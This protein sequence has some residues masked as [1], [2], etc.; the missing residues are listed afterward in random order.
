MNDGSNETT[1]QAAPRQDSRPGPAE[2]ADQR[3]VNTP[4][5]EGSGG[6]AAAAAVPGIVRV[7]ANFL[8]LPLFALDNKHLRT[9]DGI[10]CSGTFRRQGQTY[11]FTFTATRNAGTFYPGP[12]A[13]SVHFAL[14]SF[15]TER[16]LP[17]QNPIVFTW[18][19]LCGRLDIH[20]SGKTIR[21]LRRALLATKGLM[22]D[23]HHALYLKPDGKAL[24]SS[25][26]LRRVVSLYDELEFF[27]TRRQDGTTADVNAVWLSRWYLDNLNALYSGPLQFGLWRQL[28]EHSFIASRLYE[29]LFFKFYRGRDELRFNYATLVK[30]IPARMER[31]ASDAKRQLQP[32]FDLLRAAG[33]LAHAEWV[34]NTAGDPQIVLRRGPQLHA[35]AGDRGM[36]VDVAEEDFTLH[37]IEN[38]RLPEGELVAEF[39]RLW[40]NANFRPSKAEVTTARELMDKYGR[41][42]LQTALPAVVRR[43][44]QK[45]PDAKTFVAAV[46]YVDE[47]LTEHRRR[48]HAEERERTALAEEAGDQKAAASRAKDQAALKLLWEKLPEEQRT[49]IREEV[50]ARQPQG[51]LKFPTMI[52]RLCIKELARQRGL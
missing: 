8:R 47:V 4:R 18:R 44:K 11:D 35:V 16:G 20:C 41:Q 22:I 49:T 2:R 1:P 48:Q 38:V 40:G 15:A 17:V 6:G 9:M 43:M 42:A 25:E 50:L 26:D 24:D 3:E 31:Y 5:E 39:H 46:R 51:L 7:E 27:G 10:R 32:A 52:E 21:E 12:L 30:F 23:S 45:W 36:A 19:E 34:A 29:F 13:R 28:N 33:L 37:Q 14:L